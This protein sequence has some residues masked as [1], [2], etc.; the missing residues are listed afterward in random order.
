MTDVIRRARH[1]V[2]LLERGDA[3]AI[4]DM[5]SSRLRV[6]AERGQWFVEDHLREVWAPTV[7]TWAQ[8]HADD[9]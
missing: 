6:A 5:L 1:V 8:D 7:A 9:C 2:D 4:S 3:P